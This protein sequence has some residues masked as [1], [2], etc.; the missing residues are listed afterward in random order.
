MLDANA[1]RVMIRV[2]APQPAVVVGF[3]DPGCP[4]DIGYPA[5]MFLRESLDDAC[6]VRDWGCGYRICGFNGIGGCESALFIDEDLF[7][8]IAHVMPLQPLLNRNTSEPVC[9]CQDEKRHG[10]V[11][12]Q[13]VHCGLERRRRMDNN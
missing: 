10:D 6:P 8:Q 1:V 12:Q 7:L 5:A 13:A 9:R 4:L 11:R 3:V 2:G